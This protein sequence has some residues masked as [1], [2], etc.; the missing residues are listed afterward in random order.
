MVT[1]KSTSFPTTVSA[2]QVTITSISGWN[3]GGGIVNGRWT[4]QPTFK[5]PPVSNAYQDMLAIESQYNGNPS[6]TPQSTFTILG[7]NFGS[8][9]GSIQ[10]LDASL[11]PI[12]VTINPM[13]WLNNQ[14]TIS[15]KSLY[16]FTSTNVGR[17]AWVRVSR[18]RNPPPASYPGAGILQVK[19]FV[20]VIKARG[21]GQCTWYVAKRRLDVNRSIPS[22]GAYTIT[23]SITPSYVPQMWDVLSYGTSHASII[24]SNPVRTTSSGMT[25]WTFVVSEMNALTDERETSDTRTFS[26]RNGAILT[27]IGSRA[28]STY[29]ADGY[30]R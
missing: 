10:F 24:T 28:G 7:M 22:P 11:Q 27:W 4:G 1:W 13:Q 5:K 18:D 12:P 3:A 25:T 9:I 6:Y 23:A 16:N 17:A 29:K 20:G 26:V 14:V 30:W 19:G 15:A 21:Y 2:S 8:Q